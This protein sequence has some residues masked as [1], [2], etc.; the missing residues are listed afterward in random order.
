MLTIEYG[1]ILSI[2]S[3]R[4]HNRMYF[5]QST[6]HIFNIS[7]AEGLMMQYVFIGGDNT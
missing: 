6:E 4:S 2:F 5:R 3:K 7:F 1:K